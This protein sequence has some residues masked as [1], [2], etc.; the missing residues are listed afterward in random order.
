[1]CVSTDIIFGFIFC[2]IIFQLCEVQWT[3]LASLQT[4]T[5]FIYYQKY[6]FIESFLPIIQ[7]T[8]S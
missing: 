7:W 3:K 2:G 1:M 6:I 8:H 4:F 5:I